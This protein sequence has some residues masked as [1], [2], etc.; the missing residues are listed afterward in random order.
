MTPAA[1]VRPSTAAPPSP[2]DQQEPSQRASQGGQRTKPAEK[3]TKSSKKDP[4]KKSNADD[5]KPAEKATK[6]SKKAPPEKT[7]AD[8]T[9]PAAKKPRA[10]ALATKENMTNEAEPSQKTVKYFDE[11]HRRPDQPPLEVKAVG[12]IW[13]SDQLGRGLRQHTWGCERSLEPHVPDD[14]PNIVVVNFPSDFKKWTTPLVP[15]DLQ[16]FAGGKNSQPPERVSQAVKDK[17]APKK[18]AKAKAEPKPVKDYLLDAVRCKYS[19]QGKGNPVVRVEVREDRYDPSFKFKQ[20]FQI[21][22]K[23]A[24][25]AHCAM[26]I[27]TTFANAFTHMSCN[28]TGI[29]YKQCRDALIQYAEARF[30]EERPSPLEDCCEGACPTIPSRPVLWL[31]DRLFCFLYS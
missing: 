30:R 21:V 8:D 24:M 6:S 4:P 26:S 13:W 22:V 23:D 18:A 25:T 17:V 2:V 5:T 3:A 7:D 16:K 29:N 10:S 19:K 11:K 31:L 20:R 28:P 15:A 12:D 9:K 1:P 27:C 14:N